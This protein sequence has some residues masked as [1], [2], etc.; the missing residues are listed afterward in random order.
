MFWREKPPEAG[1]S[2]EIFGQEMIQAGQC[3][4]SASGKREASA[5][6]IK[7]LKNPNPVSGASP[8]ILRGLFHPNAS[9][10]TLPHCGMVSEILNLG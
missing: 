10:V 6:D 5:W 3:S 1:R 7:E 4:E 9:T 8:S 2:A